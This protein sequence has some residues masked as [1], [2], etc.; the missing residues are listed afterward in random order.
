M[1]KRRVL[2]DLSTLIEELEEEKR[3]ILKA[4]AKFG[5]F[6]KKNSVM[7]YN[8]AMTGY[9]DLMIRQ[10]KEKAA[11]SQVDSII[12]FPPSKKTV[13]FIVRLLIRVGL[14]PLR[15][16][17]AAQ[18]LV[19]EG[20][21]DNQERH[22]GQRGRGHAEG[23]GPLGHYLGRAP[24]RTPQVAVRTQALR[25][26]SGEDPG[27]AGVREPHE[28]GGG[29]QR[30]EVRAGRRRGGIKRKRRNSK[31]GRCHAAIVSAKYC[32]RASFYF[33]L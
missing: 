15:L 32:P 1:L 19:P 7:T 22:R 30:D 3:A 4:S 5:L 27:R 28:G 21:R 11:G 16:T 17:D 8:D 13:L 20:D 14:Q 26:Q 33:S 29:L 9:I 31:I 2:G 12:P 10:E 24:G 18:A 25:P 23:G 6:L